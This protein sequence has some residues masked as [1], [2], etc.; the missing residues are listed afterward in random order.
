MQRTAET[1]FQNHRALARYG[2]IGQPPPVSGMHRRDTC[3]A[4][5]SASR[6]VVRARTPSMVP[7]S[8]T[9]SRTS[10]DKPGNRTA[11]RWDGTG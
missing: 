6:V 4:G 3:P 11:A 5:A 1:C 2:K 10:D 7:V 9:S 8:W